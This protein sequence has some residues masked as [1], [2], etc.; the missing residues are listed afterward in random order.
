[1]DHVHTDDERLLGSIRLVT[2]ANDRK[3]DRHDTTWQTSNAKPVRFA[4]GR[5]V[6][7]PSGGAG[8]VADPWV[9]G[10]SVSPSGVISS[11]RVEPG[12]SWRSE[13]PT[14]ASDAARNQVAVCLEN[15]VMVRCY[16]AG[17]LANQRVLIAA[18]TGD[19]TYLGTDISNRVVPS[20]RA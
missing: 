18:D 11:G 14:K 19:S 10:T 15:R 17:T 1:M 2:G 5:A 7:P 4:D 20:T 3:P 8:M 6:Q 16:P 12:L 9:V 13:Q